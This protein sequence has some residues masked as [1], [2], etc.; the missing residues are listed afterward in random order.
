MGYVI[1]PDHC[2]L[3]IRLLQGTLSDFMASLAKRTAAGINGLL[4]EAGSFWQQGYY[5]HALRGERSLC[6]YLKYMA[7]NPVRSGLVATP[8]EWPYT[9]IRPDW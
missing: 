1:M 3:A 4:G 8:N 9:G 2:H 6:A 7:Y 5:D